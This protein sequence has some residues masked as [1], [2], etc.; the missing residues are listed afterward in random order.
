MFTTAFRS[1]AKA[2]GMYALVAALAFSAGFATLAF[3]ITNATFYACL[4]PIS[5][6]L[7]NVVKSPA[8]P[9]GCKTGDIKVRWNQTGPMGPQGPQGIQGLA[10]PAGPQG[11]QGPDGAIGPT[12]P[13]GPEGAAGPAGPMG[14]QGPAGAT[15]TFYKRYSSFIVEHGQN[16][17]RENAGVASCEPGDTVISGGGGSSGYGA[18]DAVL[19]NTTAGYDVG[20]Q[21]QNWWITAVNNAALDQTVYVMAVCAH[22][23]P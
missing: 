19:V 16:G 9:R 21:T 20:T 11:P 22:G 8:T 12:G 13:Q 1:K 10:G 15:I 18:S 2:L 5:K 14:P 6:T 23:G 3:A 17:Y 4:S 7:Y